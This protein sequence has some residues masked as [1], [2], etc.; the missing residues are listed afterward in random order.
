[1][2]DKEFT[3]IVLDEGG[4]FNFH[5]NIDGSRFITSFVNKSNN[6]WQVK[7]SYTDKVMLRAYSDQF[8]PSIIEGNALFQKHGKI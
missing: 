6:V 2:L 5:K 1:M 3:M 7:K 4:I 8:S